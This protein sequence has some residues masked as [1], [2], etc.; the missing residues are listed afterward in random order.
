MPL[1]DI[2]AAYP[3]G[4]RYSA[5]TMLHGKPQK[6]KVQITITTSDTYVR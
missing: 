2:C 5:P 6:R 4:S 3:A 1:P